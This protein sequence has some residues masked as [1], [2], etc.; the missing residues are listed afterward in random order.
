MSVDPAAFRAALGHFCSGVTVISAD[1][2]NETRAITASAFTSVSLSPPLVLVC[3]NRDSRINDV[4][5]A[6]RRYAV[7]ILTNEQAHVSD[8]F[9]RR[10]AREDFDFER[11][12]DHP[13]VAGALLHLAMDVSEIFDGGDHHIYLGHV[14]HVRVGEG[15]PLIYFRGR[16]HN[17]SDGNARRA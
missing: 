7:S 15:E 11:W 10:A 8:R 4:I 3:V 14:Q 6:S 17:G 2:G 13:V 9:G 5:R 16:Y 12:N 1:D